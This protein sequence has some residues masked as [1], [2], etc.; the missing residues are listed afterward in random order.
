M[1]G[2]V[3][4]LRGSSKAPA[5]VQFVPCSIEH[6]GKA[7]IESHFTPYVTKDEQTGTLTA[8]FR[9]YPLVGKELELP[10]DYR[11]FVLQEGKAV[12]EQ[13]TLRPVGEFESFK[14]WNW[15]REASAADKYQ[16]AVGWLS[17][18]Q[19]IHGE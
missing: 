9:G 18:A 19:V 4:E 12:T 1:S 17:L 6:N 3:I 2:T 7:N 16:Q 13:R 8:S 10:K 14:Y 11:G 15:D 5:E